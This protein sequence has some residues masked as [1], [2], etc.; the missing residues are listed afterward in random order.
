M[1]STADSAN[2]EPPPK[3]E[4]DHDASAAKASA[5]RGRGCLIWSVLA[6]VTLTVVLVPT[7]LVQ[8]FRVGQNSLVPAIEP[9]NWVLIDRLTPRISDYA[10]GD[11]VLVTEWSLGFPRGIGEQPRLVR[12]IGQPGDTVDFD[13]GFVYVTPPNGLPSREGA[14]PS[15]TTTCS[16]LHWV[17]SGQY[18][19]LGDDRR[20]MDFFLCPR[21]IYRDGIVGRLWQW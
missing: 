3:H 17:L 14:A 1:I 8:P 16:D 12:I 7:F 9:G 18:F 13:K 19:V 5:R 2:G 15:L 21:A 4:T 10:R 20:G 6:A 11:I